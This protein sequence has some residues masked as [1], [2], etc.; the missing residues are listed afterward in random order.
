MPLWTPQ[1]EWRGQEA[2]IIGGGSSL[3]DFDFNCLREC[4]VIGCNDA[5]RLG[6]D[7]V[8]ICLFGDASWWQK[9]KFDLQQF[10]GRKVTCA[11]SLRDLNAE[12]LLQMNR[13]RDGIQH[14][15]ILGWNYSTGAA[16]VN[17]AFSLGATTIYLLGFDMGRNEKGKTHWHSHTLHAI[18][19]TSFARHV[20]GF[21]TLA[22]SLKRFPDVKV[23]NVTD[24]SSKLPVFDRLTFSQFLSR[25]V[26]PELRGIA[27]CGC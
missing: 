25:L 23:W 6:A 11:P 17:L 20:R 16:A 14:G 5:F 1:P 26:A 12:D 21:Y 22:Q 18:H 10:S 7:L 19:D 2:V 8:D 13:L 4:N 24:G 27:P 3:A 9:N 15:C